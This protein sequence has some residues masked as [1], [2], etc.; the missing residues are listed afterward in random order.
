MRLPSADGRVQHL[1]E[2]FQTDLALALPV[3][4]VDDHQDRL[5]LLIPGKRNFVPVGSH[6][7]D[8]EL[9]AFEMRVGGR[10][11]DLANDLARRGVRHEQVDGGGP[12]RRR[13]TSPSI[14]RG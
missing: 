7:A 6:A 2:F 14:H 11:G 3:V 13:R 8:E 9:Q 10:V 4:H 5:P 1:V 12:S